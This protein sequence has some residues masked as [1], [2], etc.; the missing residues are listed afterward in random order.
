ML[1]NKFYNTDFEDMKEDFETVKKYLCAKEKPYSPKNTVCYYGFA[2]TFVDT[3]LK[4]TDSQRVEFVKIARTF[5]KWDEEVKVYLNGK[6]TE[7]SYHITDNTVLVPMKVE[8]VDDKDRWRYIDL[9]MD[10]VIFKLDEL[11]TIQE[12]NNKEMILNSPKISRL[13][14]LLL[15]TL[16]RKGN[17]LIIPTDLLYS[18]LYQITLRNKGFHGLPILWDSEVM[19]GLVGGQR[20]GYLKAI[21]YGLLPEY[22]YKA[23]DFDCFPMEINLEGNKKLL[24]RKQIG[25]YFRK[26]IMLIG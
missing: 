9:V 11:R 3:K 24:N 18:S 15:Y 12:L 8:D 20:K 6:L 22:N 4:Q 7:K 10:V 5:E 16:W 23:E 21:P 19:K 26:K 25:S 14:K 17:K 2:T 1:E 13:N